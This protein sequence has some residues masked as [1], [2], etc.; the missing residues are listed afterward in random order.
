MGEDGDNVCT[1]RMISRQIVRDDPK[2]L[3]K[4]TRKDPVLTQVMRCVNKGWPNQ[5]SDEL[6]NYKEL[7]DSR[8]TEHG[9]LFYESRV[10]HT[11]N[12]SQFTGSSVGLVAPRTLWNAEDEAVGK[13]HCLL[14]E[15]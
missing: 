11:F 8:S 2:L 6:R 5:C 1:V 10:V 15:N 3:V 4:E 14:I 12:S 9:C 13:V 7:D